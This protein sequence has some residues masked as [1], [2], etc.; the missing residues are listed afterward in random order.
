M[1]LSELLE[2]VSV[3]KMF[4]TVYGSMVQT[5]DVEI[6]NVRYDSRTVSRGDVFVA[7][8]GLEADGHRYLQDVVSKKAKA[9]IIENDSVL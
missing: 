6:H 4:Q 1:R 8:R 3:T 2:G 7:I 9:V 5:H